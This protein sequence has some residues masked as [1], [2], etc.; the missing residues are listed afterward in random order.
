R[1]AER[2]RA[3]GGATFSGADAFQLHDTYGFPI[4]LTLEMA[5]EQGLRVDEESFSSLME[6]QRETA[7]RDAKAKKLGNADVSVYARLLDTSGATDFLGYTDQEG[8]ARILGLIVGG[9]AADVAR[10]G[11]KVEIVLDRTPFYAESGGQLADK[12]TITVD[13]RGAADVEDV[14]KPLPGLFVHRGTVRSGELVVDDPVHA[15]IDTG[16]RASVSR[17]HSATHLIHSALRNALGA[18]T[19]QAGSENQPG[20][21]RFDFTADRPL[22]TE[23]LAEVEEEVNTVLADDIQVRD[24]QTSLDEALKMGALAMFGEKYG[25]RVRVVEMS[26]YSRELCGGTHVPATGRLGVVKVLGESSVGSGV[27]RIEAAVGI[28]AFRRLSKE[29][30]LVGQLSEQLKAPREELPERIDSLVSRVRTAEKEIE[31]LRAAQVLQAAAGLAEGA[32]ERAGVLLATH[33]AEDGA[34][35]DDLRKLALDVR[36]R[37]GEERPAVVAVAGVPKDRPVV[38]VAANKAA[39]KRGLKAGDLVGTAARELGGGGGGKPDVAQGGGTDPAAVDRALGA[40]EAR[41][42]ESA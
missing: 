38:V 41:V 12:G 8:E 2:T 30:M 20:R 4:D 34:S 1:A 27:R 6:R 24:F 10:A 16:R 17:S 14:Q 21:L 19:G 13:G 42:G 26:D 23:E 32:R 39:Q 25:D 5:A 40:I 28:D 9:Q 11:E 7:K 37:L 35:G 22:R 33:R 29:S 18:S 31:R 3:A 15:A 36:G